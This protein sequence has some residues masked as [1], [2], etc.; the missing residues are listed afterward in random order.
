MTIY[1][2]PLI[3]GSKIA[4]TAFSAGISK[5]V[6]PRFELVVQHLIAQGFKPIIGDI[7]YHSGYGEYTPE[8]RADELMSFLMR[9]DIDA[10]MPPWG[11]QFAMDLLPL[12]DFSALKNAKPKWLV[13][14]SDVSTVQNALTCKLGWATCHAL[15]LMQMVPAQQDPLSAKIFEH[16]S[17]PLGAVFT[18]KSSDYFEPIGSDIVN[19]P[20]VPYNLTAVTRW[21]KLQNQ[22]QVSG[23]LLGGC[24]D[25]L[26]HLFNSPFVDINDFANRYD[27][28]VLLYIENAELSPESFK[29]ALQG[30][31]YRGVFRNINGLLIGRNPSTVADYTHQDAIREVFFNANFP[32]FYDLDIGHFPPNLTLINGSFARFDFQAKTITQTLS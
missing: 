17:L 15:N 19:N 28:G 11:G 24:L 8:Q 21:Q 10:V 18:Q 25:T 5:A 7:L 1:P 31:L 3:K 30:L 13:G 12:L 14:F 26:M 32:V 22:E 27:D 16:L 9:D 2:A 29:R 6:S 4:I 20:A 23:R